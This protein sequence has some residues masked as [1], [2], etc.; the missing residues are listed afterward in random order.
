MLPRR[1]MKIALEKLRE[2]AKDRPAGYLEEVLSAGNIKGEF[3]VVTAE[4]YRELRG[5]YSRPATPE[6]APTSP[7]AGA[8]HIAGLG[9][10]V[11]AVARP[12]ARAID[13]VAGT[14]LSNCKGCERRKDKLN[15]LASFR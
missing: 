7:P 11:A 3:L 5:K 14:K 1:D 13:R 12:I 8:A 6:P 2:R 4:K 9:D 10:A 15:R